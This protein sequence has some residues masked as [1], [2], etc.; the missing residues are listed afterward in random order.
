MQSSPRKLN[1][2]FTYKDYL[3]WTNDNERWELIDG[4]AYD[5]SPA[6]IRQHQEI[7]GKLFRLISDIT[8]KGRC[9]TY[10]APFDIR[11]SEEF[12]SVDYEED[13]NITTVVQP[14]ISV[15]CNTE[16]L[17]EKGA[18]GAPD[19]VVEILSPSTGYKDQTTKLAL[20]ERYRV[21]EYWLV[22]GDIPSVMVYRL[23]SDDFYKKPDYYRIDESV[24]SSV[25]GGADIPLVLFVRKK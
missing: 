17:D 21:K 24:N 15:F 20:Y 18:H 22:N 6:P 19:L 23:G 2:K 14:D 1:E 10:I 4:I 7:Q 13:E 8:D 12:E 11:L 16:I 9:E 5:M 25:L 3:S